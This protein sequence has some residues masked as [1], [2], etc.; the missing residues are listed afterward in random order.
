MSKV[1]T[2]SVIGTRPE[3]IKMEPIVQELRTHRQ[4]ETL[5]VSTA[6]HR[7]MLDQVFSLFQIVPDVDLNI[8]QPRQSLNDI[9]SRTVEGLDRVFRDHSPECVLVQGDTTTAFAAAL[10]AFNRKIPVG[11]VEAGLRSGGIWNPYPE[12]GNRRLISSIASCHFAP[13][14]QSAENLYKEN[15]ARGSVFVTGN[16][17]IDCLLRVAKNQPQRLGPPPSPH[18]NIQS[19]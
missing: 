14:K 2:I 17:G 16:S 12:E 1:K 10:A 15:I 7:Q 11:H 19:P 3:A 8:M 13:T 9:V 4:T 5:V 18:I 6:Q